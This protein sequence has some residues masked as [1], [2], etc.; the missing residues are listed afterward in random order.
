MN[1]VEKGVGGLENGHSHMGFQG[2]WS[3]VAGKVRRR[4]CSLSGFTEKKGVGG[5]VFKLWDLL[6]HVRKVLTRGWFLEC[7][8]Y[9][10]PAPTWLSRT[11]LETMPPWL[12]VFSFLFFKEKKSYIYIYM[13]Q[14]FDKK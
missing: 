6:C 8:V 9:D 13:G 4:R 2:G 1:E 11:K 10:V 5:K 12:F 3:W 14:T 7:Q